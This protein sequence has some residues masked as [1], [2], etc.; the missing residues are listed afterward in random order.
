M[1]DAIHLGHASIFK[2]LKEEKGKSAVITF[3]NHPLNILK[4]SEI[5]PVC[6]TDQ[7]LN[8]IK[9]YGIDAAILLEFTQ[10]LAKMSYTDFIKNLKES[11]NFKT[12]IAG[13]DIAI[14]HNKLGNA[15]NLFK[16][17]KTFDFSLKLIKKIRY[18]GK[19]ISSTWIREL[20]EE[21]NFFLVEKLINRK[22][23]RNQNG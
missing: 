20:I 10:S 4:N 6:D 1:F 19:I 13:E 3:F 12:L 22:Y 23:Q 8:L 5:F 14:G 2:E 17:E 15:K 7:R 11:F 9:S 16:L 18:E 21:K